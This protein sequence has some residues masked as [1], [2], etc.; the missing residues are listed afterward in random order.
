MIKFNIKKECF[1]NYEEELENYIRIKLIKSCFNET[2]IKMLSELVCNFV[3]SLCEHYGQHFGNILIILNSII[4]DKDIKAIAYGESSKLF[5]ALISYSAGQNDKQVK[6]LISGASEIYHLTTLERIPIRF[7]NLGNLGVNDGYSTE[8]QRIEIK[9]IIIDFLI[10][11]RGD[12]EVSNV[13]N[14]QKKNL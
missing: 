6:L 9:S 14:L 7:L 12:I 5:T 2:Q 3:D 11:C 8:E 1:E 4:D 10:K 13:Y